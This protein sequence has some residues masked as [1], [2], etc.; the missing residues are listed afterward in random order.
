MNL[1]WRCA[2]F[3][4]LSPLVVR[5]SFGASIARTGR[6]QAAQHHLPAHRRSGLRRPLLPRQSDS[7]T[8]NLDRLHDEGVRFTDFHVSPTCSPTRSA[9]MTGRHE[10]KNGV[11]HTILERERLTLQGDDA[12]PGAEIRRLHDRHLR[13]V[14]PRRRARPLARQTRLR[15]NVHPRRRRHR[16]NLPRQLRRCARA[17]P[18]STRP[19]CTTASSRRPKATAPMSSSRQAT[20]WIES[21]KGKQPFFC[22]IATNAPHAPLQ[23]RP[24]DEKR[25]TDKV[26]TQR[27]QVLRHDRQHRR[28][29][30]PAS[31]EAARSGASNATRSSSS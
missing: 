6:C 23:V 3:P 28:Q 12:R 25:Y 24:E 15:R 13:Q 7:Q 5:R 2:S 21:V 11:T 16:P 10:F 18:T 27:G 4:R 8:P 17:T 26:Q 9:L 31:G 14:A 1:L 22:Y 20:H 30:R 19:S 29:R